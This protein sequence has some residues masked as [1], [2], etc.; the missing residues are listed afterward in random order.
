MKLAVSLCCHCVSLIDGNV[1]GGAAYSRPV[2]LASSAVHWEASSGA[3]ADA[4][5]QYLGS[6]ACASAAWAVR[7]PGFRIVSCTGYAHGRPGFAASQHFF[8][9]C[10]GAGAAAWADKAEAV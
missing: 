8:F 6:R 2:A 1:V 3:S 10:S 4:G 9:S 5:T 7:S